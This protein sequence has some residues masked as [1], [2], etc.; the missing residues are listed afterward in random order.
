MSHAHH[1][2]RLRADRSVAGLA[3]LA[4]GDTADQV[5]A[6]HLTGAC[7]GATPTTP[8]DVTRVIARY[9]VTGRYDD[10]PAAVRKEAQRGPRT[11]A[12]R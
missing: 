11:D 10:H 5:S 9:V 1:V 3:G 8:G 6:D 12:A 4:T 2:S 7:V